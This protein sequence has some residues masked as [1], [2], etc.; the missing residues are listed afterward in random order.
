[1]EV[2]KKYK[3]LVG[4]LVLIVAIGSSFY[5]FNLKNKSEQTLAPETPQEEKIKEIS[6]EDIGLTL[7]PSSD[8]RAIIMEVT[9]LGGISSLEY[10][11]TYDAEVVAEGERTTAPRGVVGSPIEVKPSDEKISR[12]ITLGTCSGKVCKYDKVVG[13]LKIVM[14]VNFE[15]GEVGSLE[16]T[17]SL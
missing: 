10:E 11:V 15:N 9:K 7:T 5:F 12:E 6:L 3:V 13:P 2:F 14:K 17:I 8:K 16:E 1:M 4:L